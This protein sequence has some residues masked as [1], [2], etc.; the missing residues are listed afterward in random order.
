MV[1]CKANYPTESSRVMLGVSV[2]G[3]EFHMITGEKR[4]GEEEVEVFAWEKIRRW[5]YSEPDKTFSFQY[6]FKSTQDTWIA[7]ETEQASISSSSSSS[8]SPPSFLFSL[9]FACLG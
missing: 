3:L 9:S 5:K 7:C 6:F 8:S 4:T 1:P 2:E